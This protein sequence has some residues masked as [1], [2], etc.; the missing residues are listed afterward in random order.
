MLHAL[1]VLG[2]GDRTG[3]HA[4]AVARASGLDLLDVG[5][6]L[7]LGGGQVVDDDPCVTRL[8][9]ELLALLGER[10]DLGQLGQVRAL[11]PQLVGLRVQGLDVEQLQLGERVGFQRV[12][13]RGGWSTGR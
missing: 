7:R 13:L 5:V 4:V 3:V 11:V 8:V 10:G 9:V 6:G 12:L 2:V 1:E